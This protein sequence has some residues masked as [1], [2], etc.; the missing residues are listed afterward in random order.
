MP[1]EVFQ[2]RLY[3]D[4]IETLDG[5]LLNNYL[6][7]EVEDFVYDKLQM[8]SGIEL[9]MDNTEQTHQYVVRH[10][11]VTKLPDKFTFWDTDK[12]GL[13][14]KTDMQVKVGDTV[15]FYAIT[16]HSSEKLIYQGRKFILVN[17]QDLYIAKRGNNIICLNGNVLLKPV[18]K[19]IKVLE[20]EKKELDIT[21]A[22]VFKTGKINKEYKDENVQDDPEIKE[23]ME[24]LLTGMAVRFL[25][26][27][28]YLFLDGEKYIVC[29]N[30]E[31]KAYL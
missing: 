25:E 27:E 1:N 10:G 15:W 14:W 20:Y 8:K 7:I 17:Y 11:I 23:G 3:E 2:D 9:W 13:Q 30:N 28:P 19:T 18:Y 31:I 26:L 21:K 29:Q 5:L 24:V 12:N 22:I 6:L 4:E 16:S